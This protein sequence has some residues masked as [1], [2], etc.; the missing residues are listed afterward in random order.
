MIARVFPVL[1]LVSFV[2]AM[3]VNQLW[4]EVSVDAGGRNVLSEAD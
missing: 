3:L 1:G 2:V 4:A